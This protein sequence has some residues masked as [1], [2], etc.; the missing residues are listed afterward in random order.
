VAR[1]K[2]RKWIPKNPS[3][4]VGDPREIVARS[5]WEARAMQWFD[6][7]PSV[8]KWNSEGLVI[9]YY[10]QADQKMR[11]YFV[12]FV[13]QIKNR[14]G[15][16]K[17]YA[18]EVKPEKETLPPPPSRNRKQMLESVTTYQVNQDKWKTAREFCHSKGMEFLV[19]TEYD[20]GI[21]KRQN[22]N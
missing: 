3:K 6:M 11:R 10:S 2:P 14:A 15:E 8:I 22:G 13:V 7:N 20:L 4:Y 19:M 5:S 1:P 18:I 9:P 16:L 12:D 21:K 17:I